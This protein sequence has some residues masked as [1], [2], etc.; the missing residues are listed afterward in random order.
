M[1]GNDPITGWDGGAFTS[2]DTD[3]VNFDIT[4]T[5]VSAAVPEPGV[6]G[7]L[8]LGLLCIALRKKQLTICGNSQSQMKS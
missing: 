7:L 5:G 2:A 8:A 1:G 3:L 6:V 4:L